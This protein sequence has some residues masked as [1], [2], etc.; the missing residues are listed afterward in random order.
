MF[1]SEK[2]WDALSGRLDQVEM[3]VSECAKKHE[4]DEVKKELKENAS[5]I[6]DV[7][8][9]TNQL[10]VEFAESRRWIGIIAALLAFAIPFVEELKDSVFHTGETNYDTELNEKLIRLE[11][12]IEFYQEQLEAK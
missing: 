11:T 10:K 4:V 2:L 3:H 5:L 1:G 8:D 7:K 6:S 9:N 12:Q